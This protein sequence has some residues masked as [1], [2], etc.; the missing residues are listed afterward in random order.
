MTLTKKGFTW[1]VVLMT[2]AWSMGVAAFLP[3]IAQAE[4]TVELEPGDIFD[5]PESGDKAVFLVTEGMK[6]R[7][8]PNGETHRSWQADFAGLNHLSLSQAGAF[9]LD[10]DQPGVTFRHGSRLVKIT[11]DSKVYAVGPDNMRHWIASEAI[12]IAL[13]GPAWATLV[14][15]VSPFHWANYGEGSDITE[16]TPHNGQI[17]RV[18]GDD[19]LWYVWDGMRHEISGDLPAPAAGDVRVVSAEVLETV[20]DSG[21]SVTAATVVADPAQGSEEEVEEEVEEGEEPA[22]ETPA[23]DLTLSLSAGTPASAL[24]PDKATHV[25]YLSFRVR[26]G[27]ESATLDEIQFERIG[28]G[29]D[30]N[31]DKVWLEVDGFPV[32]NEQSVSSDDSVTLRPQYTVGANNTVEFD[33]VANLVS[34]GADNSMQD[35]FQIARADLVDANGANVMGSFPVRGNLMSYSNYTPA[36]ITI[37][38]KGASSDIEVGDEG[39]VTGEFNLDFSSSNE[40]DGEIVYVR[41]KN[42]GTL[43]TANMENLGLYYDGEE[44]TSGISMWGDY[45]TFM[46]MED[47]RLIEDGKDRTYEIR[48]DISD[49]DDAETVIWELE[50]NRDLHVRELSGFGASVTNSLNGTA[51]NQLQTYTL[52]AGQFTVSL[53][54]SSPSNETYAPA[55]H[56]IVAMVARVDVGQKIQVDGLQ[57]WLHGDSTST[58]NSLAEINGDIERAEL[59][60]NDDRIGS[61]LTTV[62]ASST[63]PA[64]DIG[65]Y[66]WYY[67]FNSS[68]ELVDDDLLTL[69]IDLEE[70][71][72]ATSQYKFWISGSD[73]NHFQD[74]EYVSS[75]DNVAAANR[76]GTATSRLIEINAASVAL[77][78]NDGYSSG[79]NF[80]AGASDQLLLQFVVEAGS[81][82]DIRVN[83][84]N[85][86]MLTDG[87]SSSYLSSNYTKITNCFV[88]DDDGATGIG[89]TDDLNNSGALTF[90]N[91]RL[92]IASSAQA[93]LGLYCDLQS[94]LGA[95]TSVVVTM[96]ASDSDI[97]DAEGEDVSGFT[98]G[99]TYDVTGQSID[100]VTGGILRVGVDGDTPNTALV[101][102][103]ASDDT[104]VEVGRWRFIAED[105]DIQVTD[106]YFANLNAAGTASSSASDARVAGWDLYV[107]GSKV[108][109]R[110]MSDGELHFDIEGTPIE[111]PEDGT[112]KASLYA[113][114]NSISQVAETQVISRPSLYSLT[115]LSA[116]NGNTMSIMNAG[117]SD[118]VTS[119]LPN[120][121]TITVSGTYT[122]PASALEANTLSA[123]RTIPTL[124]MAG[125]GTVTNNGKDASATLING[126]SNIFEFS[127]AA[128]AAGDLA[129]SQIALDIS[130]SCA[131]GATIF[132][133]VGQTP[134]LKLYDSSNT[135]ITATFTSNT[136][137]NRLV[138]ALSSVENISEGA[139]KSYRVRATL[140]SFAAGDSLKVT[141]DDETTTT[142]SAQTNTNAEDDADAS[143]SSDLGS[144]VWTDNSGTV[145]STTDAHW[146]V[147][148]L[149]PGLDDYTQT[150]VPPSS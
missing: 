147:G 116:G 101:V 72:D 131:A 59:Y 29:D 102:A 12:A 13:Y 127:V 66:E 54:V 83:T 1:S 35:G 60:I 132:E 144:F 27:S 125:I 95:T 15:D 115:A 109:G 133:C 70:A 9:P 136:T 86:D 85:F 49:G 37:D 119:T 111:V 62:T 68:F 134:N 142:V 117:D 42:E 84:L 58:V 40:K 43:N 34:T 99:T 3:A 67:N 65:D 120:S 118:G 87:G 36:A 129:W 89:D 150:H 91:M 18:E 19:T 31:F 106:L 33:L 78:R 112:V 145:D 114:Y 2:I 50:N 130:G 100:F 75:G 90:N 107:G 57:L 48:A 22:E 64:G 96:D 32:S 41:L 92:D 52:D 5:V 28:Q 113:R 63:A 8:F 20:A 24:T 69:V 53:D 45:V 44:V 128:N 122:D 82:S 46:F 103:D 139:S 79:E 11:T 16:A 6:S 88:S 61:S 124:S 10:L 76:T 17:V 93:E 25:N 80:V 81:A 148:R 39:I 56:D 23:G 149:V 26:A 146:F 55:T 137:Q 73:S 14:R 74:P 108:M 138:I 140:A 135:E 51:T 143:D 7:Y 47:A 21:D 121:Q 104:G 123:Y 98:S 126:A 71:A 141:I 30:S 77:T 4:G 110:V 94:S 97:D 105:D 38:E